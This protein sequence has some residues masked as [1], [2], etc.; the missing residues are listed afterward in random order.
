LCFTTKHHASYSGGSGSKSR[1]GH[2][3]S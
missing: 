3:L 1:P 2:R